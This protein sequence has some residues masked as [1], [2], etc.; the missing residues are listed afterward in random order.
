MSLVTVSFFLPLY[1]SSS[2]DSPPPCRLTS[3]SATR[4]AG[5]CVFS[6]VEDCT[7]FAFDPSIA[8][9]DADPRQRFSAN[10][11]FRALS[12]ALV[13]AKAA[14]VFDTWLQPDCQPDPLAPAR[15][16]S[17]YSGS[18]S[19]QRGGQ[20]PPAR[21]VIDRAGAQSTSSS[22]RTF[23]S[24]HVGAMCPIPNATMPA[25]SGSNG[26][27]AWTRTRRRSAWFNPRDSPTSATNCACLTAAR[28]CLG[29]VQSSACD[30]RH[31]PGHQSLRLRLNSGE[32]RPC[33]LMLAIFCRTRREA[34]LPPIARP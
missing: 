4:R 21:S 20:R 6:P 9:R 1:S 26:K 19:S 13:R 22:T 23:L 32:T 7:A 24:T 8:H 10:N 29:D 18:A 33:P 2:L 34:R 16:S 17:G 28:T 25:C 14:W 31:T 15:A 3:N 30:A 12:S 27:P 5:P 11:E